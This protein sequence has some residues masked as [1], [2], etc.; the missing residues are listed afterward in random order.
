MFCFFPLKNKTKI[1]FQSSSFNLHSG[2]LTDLLLESVCFFGSL[3]LICALLHSSVPSDWSGSDVNA[4]FIVSPGRFIE[5]GT[6]VDSC[7][8]RAAVNIVSARIHSLYT[9]QHAPNGVME[10][11]R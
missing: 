6:R 1:C 4:W 7:V 3:N 5:G 2:Q 10:R 9:A 8:G 11:T